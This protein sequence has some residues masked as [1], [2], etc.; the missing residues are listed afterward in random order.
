MNLQIFDGVDKKI[1]LFKLTSYSHLLHRTDKLN[2]DFLEPRYVCTKRSKFG[3]VISGV[4][5]LSSFRVIFIIIRILGI[6]ET[7]T[8]LGAK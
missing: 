8:T 1:Y 4:Q 5:I 7:L 2:L 3:G 6:Y